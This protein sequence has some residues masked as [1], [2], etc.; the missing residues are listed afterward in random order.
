VK[1]GCSFEVAVV[2]RRGENNGRGFGDESVA[3]RVLSSLPFVP[4]EVE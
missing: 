3:D 1:A 4:F 2:F